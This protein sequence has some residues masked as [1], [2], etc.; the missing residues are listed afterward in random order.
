VRQL[1][2][3]GGVPALPETCSGFAFNVFTETS[4]GTNGLE[5]GNWFPVSGVVSRNQSA[6][7]QVIDL[8][9]RLRESTFLARHH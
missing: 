7:R 8:D 6:L 1:G 2:A 5:T 4:I 3:S 9:R